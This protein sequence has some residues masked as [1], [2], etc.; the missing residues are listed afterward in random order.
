MNDN[1]T[2]N[3]AFVLALRKL[4]IVE[5]LL[6]DND[7]Q[8]LEGLNPEDMPALVAVSE[9]DG[10]HLILLTSA[11]ATALQE[12]QKVSQSSLIVPHPYN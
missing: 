4:G 5:M 8:S 7:F 11:E 12:E 3:T 9:E 2:L 6:T 1:T 10:L